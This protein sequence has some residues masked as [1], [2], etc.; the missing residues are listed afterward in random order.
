[1]KR[2]TSRSSTQI[3]SDPSLDQTK[4]ETKVFKIMY[5]HGDNRFNIKELKY[6]LQP[7][8]LHIHPR[9]EHVGIT[10]K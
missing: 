9:D 8:I 3:K 5:I 6:I 1:M 4:Y 2:L 7:E 10:K